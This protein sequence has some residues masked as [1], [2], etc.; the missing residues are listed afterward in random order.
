[1][2]TFRVGK[3]WGIFNFGTV[4]ILFVTHSC[5]HN[6]Q[7]IVVTD[8]LSSISEENA[9]FP[10]SEAIELIWK[11]SNWHRWGKDDELGLL[12]LVQNNAKRKQ[13]LS[14]PRN[15]DVVSLARDIDF[16][17]LNP[18]TIIQNRR[19]MEET[20]ED[21]RQPQKGRQNF[22][23]EFIGFVFHG[24]TITHMDSLSHFFWKDIMYGNRSSNLVT[25]RDGATVLDV[26]PVKQGILTRGVLIDL[27]KLKGTDYLWPL[28][29]YI[30]PEDLQNFCDRYNVTFFPGDALI[31]RTGFWK[32]NLQHGVV[33]PRKGA[34]GLH[35]TAMEWL[36]ARDIS[37]L[38]T[39]TPGDL[40]PPLYP[41]LDFPVHVI[42]LVGMGLTI[43][44]N[45]DFE[46]LSTYCHH[47]NQYHFML[48]VQ[49][50]PMI[51]VTGSPIN[52]IAV[53]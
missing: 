15:Y 25:A 18:A 29:Q 17:Q 10:E 7:D 19:S 33:D 1:V 21:R 13:A 30:Y 26:L 24:L 37:I 50:L 4:L 32:Y 51:G 44:D 5:A 43:L 22:A 48:S 47:H 40:L 8:T 28:R 34:P 38:G 11:L 3:M 53:F 49:P 39:D 23:A 6:P 27:P 35:P 36:K 16:N 46:E 2:R 12:N 31:L 41:T 52:P 20:G 42:G 9:T 14:I 45:C